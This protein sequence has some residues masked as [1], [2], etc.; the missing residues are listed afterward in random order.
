MLALPASVKGFRQRDGASILLVV[1]GLCLM[2]L[3]VITDLGGN[4]YKYVYVA[5]IV[6]A[7]LC[8]ASVNNWFVQSPRT[9]WALA[10][11]VPLLFVGIDLLW[12]FH[13]GGFIPDNLAN[14]PKIDENHFWIELSPDEADLPWIESI[15]DATPDD[16]RLAD[17][18]FRHSH[19]AI[20]ASIAVR[21]VVILRENLSPVTA[22]RIAT[23]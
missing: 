9:G 10:A 15:R 1:T 23:I 5:P 22:C 16:N 12:I 14:A 11:A 18:Q 13:L 8:A 3:S 2:G 20:C 4:E 21:P 6:L 17:Q 7:P 19:G